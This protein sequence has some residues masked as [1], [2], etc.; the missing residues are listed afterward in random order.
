MGASEVMAIVAGVCVV[1][2]VLSATAIFI[3]SL[4]HDCKKRDVELEEAKLR[5]E[6]FK[7]LVDDKTASITSLD[8]IEPDDDELGCPPESDCG[9][10]DD[11]PHN[12]FVRP[13][14]PRH[15]PDGILS[16]GINL[17]DDGRLIM[18]EHRTNADGKIVPIKYALEEIR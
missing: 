2:T 14:A 11:L 13:T 17:R 1:I 8:G 7:A 18:V 15:D 3:V 6:Q 10:D 9:D 12:A 16:E 5:R 4:C